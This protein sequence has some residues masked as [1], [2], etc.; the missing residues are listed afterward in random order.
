MAKREPPKAV[1][2]TVPVDS[3]N[4]LLDTLKEDSESGSFDQ[5]L[6]DQITGALDA[7]EALDQKWIRRK[8]YW[9]LKIPKK[10]WDVMEET[11]I[12]DANSKWFDADLKKRIRKA[13]DRVEVEELSPRDWSPRW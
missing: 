5:E 10:H 2:V 1:I 3:W 11:L 12:M 13:L 6:R 8:S 4:V 7:V 9:V